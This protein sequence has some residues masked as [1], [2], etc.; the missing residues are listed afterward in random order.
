MH[1]LINT[2]LNNHD[3]LKSEEIKSEGQKNEEI[4]IIKR[5]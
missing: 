2:K 5:S 1:E 4:K 3:N